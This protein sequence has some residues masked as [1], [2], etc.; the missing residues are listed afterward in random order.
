[1]CTRFKD[2]VA[3]KAKKDDAEERVSMRSK[4]KIKKPFWMEEPKRKRTRSKNDSTSME[5]ENS[6]L[7]PTKKI[8]EDQNPQIDQIEPDDSDTVKCICNSTVDEGKMVQCDYCKTWQHTSCLHIKT[9]RKD[10][11]H[12]CWNCR[13]SR[14]IKDCKDKYYLEWLTKKEF[15]SFK[16]SEE[17]VNDTLQ[18]IRF[19]SDLFHRA[20]ALKDVLPK[21]RHIIEV[22]NQ[23]IQ[24][25]SKIISDNESFSK[26]STSKV[27]NFVRTRKFHAVFFLDILVS[28]AF[29]ANNNHDFF[30]K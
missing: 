29:L 2:S 30:D 8:S 16:C 15:P 5:T 3:E 24:T 19:V 9:V 14:S 27:S 23:S 18:P 28:D 10:E 17:Q 11:E 20:Q 21:I 7:T 4:R 25:H 13:H 26:P 6:T 12:M 22:L 1:M